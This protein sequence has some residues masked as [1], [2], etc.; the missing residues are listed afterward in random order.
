M[1]KM[2]EKEYVLD[3][4]IPAGPTGPQATKDI[5]FI[6]Y[7]DARSRGN[8]TVQSTRI[9]P[10]NSPDY[11]VGTD[12]IIVSKGIYEITFC[13]YMEKGTAS[14]QVLLSLRISQNNTFTTLPDMAIK[15]YSESATH[16]SSTAIFEFPND[17]RLEAY[18][19]QVGTGTL[20]ATSVNLL[21]KKI[22]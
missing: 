5:A 21:I 6:S 9:M 18:L 4:V 11:Q 8:L 3:F 15:L 14:D 22:E 2:N 19:A 12:Y 10:N 13:G 16:F 1:N 17:L 20:S 7:A